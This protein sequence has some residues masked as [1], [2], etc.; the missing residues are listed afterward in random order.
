METS[1]LGDSLKAS[2]D[3]CSTLLFPRLLNFSFVNSSFFLY[4]LWGFLLVRPIFKYSFHLCLLLWF[5]LHFLNIWYI[6]PYIL[7]LDIPLSQVPGDLV[8]LFVST[9]CD[10]FLLYLLI[11]ADDFVFASF[12]ICVKVG[13]LNWGWFLP[14][15]GLCLWL[16]LMGAPTDLVH[17]SL[18]IGSWLNEG[19]LGSA[20]LLVGGPRL[21]SLTPAV[22]AKSLSPVRLCAIPWGRQP[23]KL[24]CPQTSWQEHWEWAAIRQW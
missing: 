18:L 17:F 15:E 16:L 24:S 22:A 21:E 11:F 1:P 7:Y 6:V 5:N 9:Y 23:T 4:Q 20:S 14:A 2:V 12:F 3:A 13:G 10:F 19:V 8:L